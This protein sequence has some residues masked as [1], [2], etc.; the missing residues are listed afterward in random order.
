MD[1]H[2][3]ERPKASTV[4]SLRH[5]LECLDTRMQRCSKEEQQECLLLWEEGATFYVYSSLGV[6][7]FFF[8]NIGVARSNKVRVVKALATQL[9]V[10]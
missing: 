5:K 8:F 1:G 3:N 2:D 10:C 4:R 9:R 7:N 6:G